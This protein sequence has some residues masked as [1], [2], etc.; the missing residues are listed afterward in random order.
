MAWKVTTALFDPRSYEVEH[1]IEAA[2]RFI[3]DV[4]PPRFTVMTLDDPS[5]PHERRRF[6][7]VNDR[8]DLMPMTP[9]AS[10]RELR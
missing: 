1:P 3:D 9:A 8:G 6:K 10:Y 4:H 7:I 2:R 5:Q